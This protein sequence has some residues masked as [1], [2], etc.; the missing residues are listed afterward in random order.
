MSANYTVI[1]DEKMLSDFINWLPDLKDNECYYLCLFARS[2]YA[3][4]EDGT[5]KF[6]HIKTDKSQLKRFICTDKK[7][8]IQKIRQLEVKIGAYKTKDGED[9]PQEALALYINVSPRN[10]Y[11]AMFALMKRLIDIQEC[12][13]SNFN[14]H[15]EALSAIQK[16]GKKKR[17]FDFDL[18]GDNMESKVIQSL[19]YNK[20]NKD[21][22]T[23]LKTRGGMHILVDL[24]KISDEFK[25]TWYKYITSSFEVDIKGDN[26][27]PVPGTHQ[28]GFTPHFINL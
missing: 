7:Y 25:N 6:P 4:N 12:K 10:Q 20:I 22:L 24:T 17:F 16:S 19:D 8:I 14:I 18:D 21:C 27:I 3:K 5:N 1:T 2:K 15:A 23:F 28:G 13:G 26:M 9:I 11:S